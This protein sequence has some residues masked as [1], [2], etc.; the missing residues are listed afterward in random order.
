[1]RR[2]GHL[3]LQN[4]A[5]TLV[6]W[7]I[8]EQIEVHV[9]QNGGQWELWAKNEDQLAQAKQVYE[10]FLAD[11]DHA[12]YRNAKER[13]VAVVQAQRKKQRDFTRNYVDVRRKQRAPVRAPLTWTLIAISSLVALWTSFGREDQLA[14]PPFTSLAL[15]AVAQPAAD[16][17]LQSYNND[18]T[19]FGLKFSSIRSGELWRIVTPIFLH[20][21]TMHLVFNM[22]ILFQL[23]RMVESRYGA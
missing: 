4:Q 16:D 13:A 21:G 15:M 6:A 2:I 23:G 10:E 17:L 9:D 22:V 1:M 20:F 8:A 19:A 5:E 14:Q 7:M 18:P 12:R 11:P 3:T